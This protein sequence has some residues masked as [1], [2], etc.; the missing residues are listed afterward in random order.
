MLSQDEFLDLFFE[1]LELPDLVK[2]LKETPKRDLK[3]AGFSHVRLA[4]ADLNLLRTMRNCLA[5][6][7]SLHRPRH[8]E[9]EA[10]EP[11][12]DTAE[13]EHRATPKDRGA[14]GQARAR[15]RRSRRV[16][17]IDPSMCGSTLRRMPVPT[18]QAVM[19][20]LMD[21]SGSMGEREKDLAKRFYMLL[22]VFLKRRYK[23]VDVVFIR[24]THD[25]QEVDEQEFFY[26]RQS[27]GT[28]VSTALDKMLAIQKER[29][30]TAD[31]NIYAAQACD[32]YT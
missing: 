32:G 23:K 20:C 12:L 8:E 30:A 4:D 6:R 18:S 22:H 5:R 15:E 1:D 31:W 19:F 11:Q 3:R 17:F 7:I 29:Y 16:A 21:V 9:I 27:G 2:T 10:L 28:I 26:S 25:A 24:H 13:H 14:Q